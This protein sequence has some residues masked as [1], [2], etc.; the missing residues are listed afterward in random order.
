MTEEERTR[1]YD[2]KMGSMDQGHTDHMEKRGVSN[3]VEEQPEQ[4]QRSSTLEVGSKSAEFRD[5]QSSEFRPPSLA[6]HSMPSAVTTTAD[7]GVA[8]APDVEYGSYTQPLVED[9]DL[10]VAIAI[11]D[12]EEEEEKLFAYAVEFDPDSKPPLFK[13]RRFRF[14]GIGGAVCFVVLAV[15]LVVGIM[16][17]GSKSTTL[18]LTLPPTDAPTAAPTSAR[19]SVFRSFFAQEVSPKVYIMGTPHYR[20]VEWIMNEDPLQMEPNNP[21]LLQRYMMAFLYYH[22]TKNGEE[23]WRSCNPP[24]GDE[25]DTCTYLEFTRL[26]NDTIAYTPK[27]D[28]IRWLSGQDECF[29][30]GVLCGNGADIVGVNLCK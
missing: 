23:S 3:P 14:Y 20:A 16:S 29:W 28:R 7:R 4:A 1:R 8:V 27:E 19:S 5:G 10:A 21:R 22:T 30:E 25:V 15:V 12:E 2:A 13:N 17:S 11:D 24:Q 26:D 9:T 18:L 6:T